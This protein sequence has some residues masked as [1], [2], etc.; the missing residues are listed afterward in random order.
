M[1]TEPNSVFN[2]TIDLNFG[3][4]ALTSDR[5]VVACGLASV[6]TLS[7]SVRRAV[8]EDSSCYPKVKSESKV[9]PKVRL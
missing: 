1:L 5:L 9:H 6:H 7:S 3:A 2:D 4:S 8:G